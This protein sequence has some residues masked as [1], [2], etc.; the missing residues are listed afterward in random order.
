[1]TILSEDCEDCEDCQKRARGFFLVFYGK[2]VDDAEVFV[3]VDSHLNLL[4]VS[5]VQYRLSRYD[6]I[7]ICRRCARQDC[8][9]LQILADCLLE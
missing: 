5:A 9:D 4:S 2:K 1:M 3:I 6:P 8:Q 7:K